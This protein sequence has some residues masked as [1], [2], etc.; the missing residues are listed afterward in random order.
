MNITSY[1]TWDYVSQFLSW[2]HLLTFVTIANI[3]GLV[4]G[5]FYVASVSMKTIIP[6]RVAAIASTAFFLGYGLFTPALPT[7]FLYGMPPSSRR[8]V[9]SRPMSVYLPPGSPPPSALLT[10]RRACPVRRPAPPPTS[11]TA[12]R[13]RTAR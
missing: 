10:P 13:R 9:P 3:L 4:G 8:C 11:S 1:F 2:Q 12:S 6:L 5:I 7:I